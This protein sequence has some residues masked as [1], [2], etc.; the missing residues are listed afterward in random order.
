MEYA[1]LDGLSEV[2]VIFF[3]YHRLSS[4]LCFTENPPTHDKKE[5]G[6]RMRDNWGK[7]SS[8]EN[9]GEGKGMRDIK[10]KQESKYLVECLEYT[11]SR[12]RFAQYVVGGTIEEASYTYADLTTWDISEVIFLVISYLCIIKA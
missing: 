5:N 3:H 10:Y 1:P 2:G 8:K 4:S 11:A 12:R 9:R 6:K 7:D